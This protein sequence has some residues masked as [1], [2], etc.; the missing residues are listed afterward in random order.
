M[1]LRNFLLAEG[2]GRGELVTPTKSSVNEW[3]HKKDCCPSFGEKHLQ[4][5]SPFFSVYS[6]DYPDLI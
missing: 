5:V 4:T 2:G 6:Y 3:P 1:K